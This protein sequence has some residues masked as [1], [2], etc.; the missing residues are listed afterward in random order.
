MISSAVPRIEEGGR[1]S[2]VL[3]QTRLQNEL[4]VRLL[5]TGEQTGNVDEMMHKAA[6]YYEGETESR[7]KK[8]SVTIVPITVI[9]MGIV[10]ALM[11]IK[12]YVSQYSE[13]FNMF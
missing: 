2:E 9:I 1:F 12:F 3:R 5:Q 6:E 8:L 10:V 11:V 4:L 7:I 13:V